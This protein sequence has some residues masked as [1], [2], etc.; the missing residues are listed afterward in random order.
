MGE[1]GCTGCKECFAE[2]VESEIA[3]M[4]CEISCVCGNQHL[5]QVEIKQ[6]VPEKSVKRM[7]QNQLRL[8]FEANPD[9][10]FICKTPD[11]ANVFVMMPEVYVQCEECGKDFCRACDVQP[12]HHEFYVC[13]EY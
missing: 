4:K 7:F 9:Q 1:C 11:C 5:T 3:A 12:F 13:E 2:W 8:L 10:Y 6:L